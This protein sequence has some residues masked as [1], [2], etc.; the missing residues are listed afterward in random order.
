MEGSNYNETYAPAV[1]LKAIHIFLVYAMHKM[2]RVHKMDVKSAFLNG[3]M[4]EEGYLQQPQGCKNLD[5]PHYCY[6]LEKVV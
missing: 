1:R 5:I 3:E 6:K 2:V 4:K